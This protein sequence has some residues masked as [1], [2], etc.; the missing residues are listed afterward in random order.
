MELMRVAASYT[1]TPGLS[2]IAIAR[3]KRLAARGW[4]DSTSI[5]MLS[6]VVSN[7][8]E[9]GPCID[10]GSKL[11]FLGTVQDHVTYECS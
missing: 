6:I 11:A 5:L 1:V 3:A 4:S 8:E 2:V 7:M 9:R 10:G